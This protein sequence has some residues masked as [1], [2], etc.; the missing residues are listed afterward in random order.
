MNAR[1]TVDLTAVDG[2]MV[3]LLGLVERRGFRLRGVAM[4]EQG[5]GETASVT[6][7]IEPR[8]AGRSLETLDLQLRRLIEVRDVS[9]SST[10]AAGALS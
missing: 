10:Q 9:Y 1:V 3:R 6:L 7:D 8:D 2:A 4:T 5:E